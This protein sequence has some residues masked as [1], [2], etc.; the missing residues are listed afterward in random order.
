M[1]E[2]FLVYGVYRYWMEA[3]YDRQLL[4]QVRLCIRLYRL[5]AALAAQTV[6][7]TGTISKEALRKLISLCCK[8]IEHS[9]ENL[10]IFSAVL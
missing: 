7:K 2:H 9:S 10:E 6:R 5:A 3:A 1:L 4:S 8:E